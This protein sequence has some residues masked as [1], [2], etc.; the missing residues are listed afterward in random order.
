MWPSYIHQKLS[1][2]WFP[3]LKQGSEGAN[4]TPWSFGWRLRIEVE[5]LLRK[6]Q[7]KV[8]GPFGCDGGKNKVG[9]LFFLGCV[10]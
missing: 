6:E 3:L 2:N 4:E 1:W 9:P 8:V 7:R 5:P 10:N